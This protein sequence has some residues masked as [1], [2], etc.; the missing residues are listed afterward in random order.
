MISSLSV[1]NVFSLLP[2]KLMHF[3]FV[4]L[5]SVVIMR[6]VSHCEPHI[7]IHEEK[8]R[9]LGGKKNICIYFNTIS[10]QA[11]LFLLLAEHL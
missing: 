10:V 3:L 9:V 5:N 7:L 6:L 11:V 1:S 8:M 4:C 2:K